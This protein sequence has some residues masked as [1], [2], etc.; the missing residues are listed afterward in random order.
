MKKFILKNYFEIIIFAA[1]ISLLYVLGLFTEHKG[2]LLIM[3]IA[4]L[5][6]ITYSLDRQTRNLPYMTQLT[7]KPVFATPEIDARLIDFDD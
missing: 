3:V 7:A 2:I 5:F 1:F 6:T 4:G